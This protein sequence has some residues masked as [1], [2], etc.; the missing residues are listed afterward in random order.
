MLIALLISIIYN[1]ERTAEWVLNLQT[2]P[3]EI[4]FFAFTANIVPI[5]LAINYDNALSGILV[6][7]AKQITISTYNYNFICTFKRNTDFTCRKIKPSH[8][9]QRDVN[10]LYTPCYHFT[11][12]FPMVDEQKQDITS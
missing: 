1:Y 12:A 7:I 10:F 8:P 11:F 5:K 9:N 4:T 3:I 2:V 6:H